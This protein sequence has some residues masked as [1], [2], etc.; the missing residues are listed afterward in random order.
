[1]VESSADNTAGADFHDP[2]ETQAAPGPTPPSGAESVAAGDVLGGRFRIISRLGSGGMGEVYRADDLT[3]GVSVA[4]KFLPPTRA[5]DPE[6]IARI[7]A[8]VRVA[9]EVAHQHVCRTFDIVEMDGRS[10]LTMEYVDGE[11]LSSLLRRIGRLPVDKAVQIARQLCAGLAAAHAQGVIHRDLKPANV[12]LD[13]RGNV[14][15]TDFGIAALADSTA[16]PN[17][18][19]GTPAYMAPEQF[20]GAA[21]TPQADLYALGLVLYEIFTGRTAVDG[22][23]RQ[24]FRAAHESSAVTPMTDL[25]EDVDPV[26]ERVI[27]RCLQKDPALRPESAFAVAAALPGG[28]PLAAALEAGETPSP[29]MVAAA[30][31]RREWLRPAVGAV[32]IGVLVL[33]LVGSFFVAEERSMFTKIAAPQRPEAL[34]QTAREIVEELGYSTDTYD[35]VWGVAPDTRYLRYLADRSRS[36]DRWSPLGSAPALLRFWY[37]QSSQSLHPHPVAGV[38]LNP[39][40]YH[41]PEAPVD[42]LALRLDMQGRLNDFIARPPARDLLTTEA[43]PRPPVDWGR[44]FERAGLDIDRFQETAAPTDWNWVVYCDTDEQH[45]WFGTASDDKPTVIRVEGRALRN[46]VVAFD[47]GYPWHTPEFALV[48]DQRPVGEAWIGFGLLV[49]ACVFVLIALRHLRQGRGDRRGANWAALIVLTCHTVYWLLS[50]SRL[51]NP[52]PELVASGFGAIA[53]GLFWAAVAWLLYLALEPFV[54]RRSPHRLVAWQRLVAG[55]WRDP[56]VG[57]DLLVGFSTG[58]LLAS[59]GSL[60]GIG[61]DVAQGT[62]PYLTAAWPVM[63]A[64]G[65]LGSLALYGLIAMVGA[66]AV[67]LLPLLLQL[68]VRKQWLALAVAWPLIAI[69]ASPPLVERHDVVVAFAISAIR[70]AG[71]LYVQQRFGLVAAWATLFAGSAL[72]Q[73]GSTALGAWHA[74]PLLTA[75]GVLIVFGAWS[76]Y[77]ALGGRSLFPASKT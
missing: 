64:R 45:T 5:A 51:P 39:A 3:L 67:T 49:L 38:Y 60:L 47:T 61:V 53:L 20:A 54:R 71:I 17:K 2:D 40:T 23:S 57:R 34:E 74:T 12:M 59:G 33:S 69:L 9:R 73:T 76:Y 42:S 62:A 6:W 1:M 4:L 63:S 77:A 43:A 24:E 28:D 15:I 48:A 41:N 19:V 21:P 18:I 30:G 50:I 58:A 27:M 72:M 70:A 68:A 31:D 7:R 32:L 75:V 11:D 13:G 52:S 37:R 29:D 35:R 46:R 16:Q 55:R 8:E 56:I 36:L 14:R 25:V 22:L 65:I 10:F 44:L 66:L 26:V